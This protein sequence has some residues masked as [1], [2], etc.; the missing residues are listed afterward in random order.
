[1]AVCS[2]VRTSGSVT[3]INP[4]AA[5]KRSACSAAPSAL[6]VPC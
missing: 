3:T 2:A 4:S 5:T 1:M 6:L